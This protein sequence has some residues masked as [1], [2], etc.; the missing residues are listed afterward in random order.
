M[1][2][3]APRVHCAIA[4]CILRAGSAGSKGVQT[5]TLQKSKSAIQ[6]RWFGGV[7]GC[8]TARDQNL[9]NRVRSHI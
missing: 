9:T 1:Q 7:E 4:Q 3:L 6:R 5:S 8:A 2:Q